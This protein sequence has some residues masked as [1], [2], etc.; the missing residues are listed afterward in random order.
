M[1]MLSE[2]IPFDSGVWAS[3][4]HSTNTVHSATMVNSPPEMLMR[5]ALDWQAQDFVRAAAVAHPG[6]AVRNEDVMA[7]DA[8]HRTAIYREFSMP[9]GIEQALA[10]VQADTVTDLAELLFLFRSDKG[11]FFTDEEVELAELLTPHMT[12]AWRQRQISHHYEAV[13][14]GGSAGLFEFEGHAVIDGTGLLYAAGD[15]F[16]LAVK[17]VA[18]D[19]VGP[20]I[21]GQLMPL[22]TAQ[23]GVLT[24]GDLEFSLARGEQKHILTVGQFDHTAH[25]TR[26]ETRVARMFA[27]GQTHSQIADELGVSQSTVRNQLA[28]IYLK[29][30]IHSKAELGHFISGRVRPR[31]GQP[32]AG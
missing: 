25:L 21:P 4:V 26:A 19:W 30:E 27:G 17:Q 15:K 11:A 32:E 22:L 12:A 9:A 16:S 18:P 29:L 24:V 13:I 23:D 5:Y 10:T 6:R 31:W 28:S 3:G 2:V 14:Q 20:N 1:G 7:L 8:Y